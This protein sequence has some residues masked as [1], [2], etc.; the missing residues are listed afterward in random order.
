M[1]TSHCRFFHL[2]HSSIISRKGPLGAS[3]PL[4][5]L[6][7]YRELFLTSKRLTPIPQAHSKPLAIAQ[8]SDRATF[9]V[10]RRQVKPPFHLP[11]LSLR[12][13]AQPALPEIPS[14]F[15]TMMSSPGFSH[16]RLEMFHELKPGSFAL[17][18]AS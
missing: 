11:S 7:I 12:T 4:I 6:A 3:L 5:Q 9:M 10:L 16:E 2:L 17:V 13:P 1:C 8:P 14:T 15:N 18:K